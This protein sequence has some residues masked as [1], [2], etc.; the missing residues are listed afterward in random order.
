MNG[1]FEFS[2][3]P[4]SIIMTAN[5]NDL[6]SEVCTDY[7]KKLKGVSKVDCLREQVN[8]TT[9]TGTYLV[10]FQDFPLMPYENNLFTHDG[11]PPLTAFRCNST[12]MDIE[13]SVNPYCEVEDIDPLTALPCNETLFMLSAFLD[14]I[15]CICLISLFFCVQYILSVQVMVFVINKLEYVIVSEG[16]REWH[17]MIIVTLM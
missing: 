8:S 10:T 4:Q 13:D 12:L 5:A 3:G 1:R 14:T 11:N 15:G 16:I 17:V 9:A 6:T 2:F 7:M